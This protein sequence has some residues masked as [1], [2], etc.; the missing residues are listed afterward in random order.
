MI[1]PDSVKAFLSKHKDV[2]TDELVYAR[3]VIR[4]QK[5]ADTL[6][7][8]FSEYRPR[9]VLDIGCGLGVAVIVLACRFDLDA[10]HL[11]DG[12]GSGEIFHDYCGDVEPWND[13]ELA[14]QMAV[15]N[16]SPRCVVHAYKADVDLTIPVD[17]I[18]SF[19]SWGTHYPV[20]TYL[21]LAKR[22]L[23]RGG[24]VAID[25]RPCTNYHSEQVHEIQA[26]GFI[27]IEQHGRRHVFQCR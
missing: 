27:L 18:V 2:G 25:L 19:K 3:Q 5:Q 9:S 22:S 8:L 21:P 1:F 12:D 15:A 26:A 16:V 14:R 11:L 13:V 20:S 23:K 7:E 6:N 17:M 24:L 4:A 10:L